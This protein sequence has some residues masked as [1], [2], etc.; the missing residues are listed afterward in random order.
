MIDHFQDSNKIL[1]YLFLLG[2][3][4][5]LIRFSSNK[6]L[7]LKMGITSNKNIF[8]HGVFGK[9]FRGFGV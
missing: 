1:F 3:R 4:C 9:G 6:K 8:L 2:K 5:V 7:I